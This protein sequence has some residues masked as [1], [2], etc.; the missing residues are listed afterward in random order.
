MTTRTLN[1]ADLETAMA[2]GFDPGENVTAIL[3]AIDYCHESDRVDYW[4]GEMVSMVE[5]A[6][7]YLGR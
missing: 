2:A 5:E 1:L 7:E 3:A 4:R 6:R